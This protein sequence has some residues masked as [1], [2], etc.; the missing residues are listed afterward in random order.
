MPRKIP[1]SLLC[2]MLI[3]I[4]ALFAVTEVG[5]VGDCYGTYGN[6]IC[7]EGEADNECIESSKQ[8]IEICPP[9]G[10]EKVFPTRIVDPNFGELVRFEYI[11]TNLSTKKG[12]SIQHVLMAWPVCTPLLAVMQRYPD[13]INVLNPG[14]GHNATLWE[15]GHYQSVLVVTPF[16]TNPGGDQDRWW[17]EM[18]PVLVGEISM[19]LNMNGLV[20]F[21][22]PIVGPTCPDV[23][24]QGQ[25][26]TF[27]QN[28]R[29]HVCEIEVQLVPELRMSVLSGDCEVGPVIPITE[30][31][32]GDDTF[33]QFLQ[34]GW[35]EVGSSPGKWCYS[36]G[37]KIVCVQCPTPP[38]PS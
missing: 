20:T 29:G 18:P 17:F 16:N 8:V 7:D 11:V 30:F 12:D 24:P 37:S 23:P 31:P 36:D 1:I 32:A 27:T 4:V 26:F 5:A 35:M 21:D 28:F 6:G 19:A 2:A 9:A 3:A 38:C 10:E 14:D 25:V 13:S 33:L 15:V 22:G 34:P